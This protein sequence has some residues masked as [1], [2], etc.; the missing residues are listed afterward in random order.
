MKTLALALLVPAFALCSTIAPASAQTYQ[1]CEAKAVTK[2]T[3][4]AL[5]GVSKTSSINKCMRAP[6]EAQAAKAVDK[7]GKKLAGPTKNSF[8]A[9][10]L[11]GG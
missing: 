8:M 6:C 5:T 1:Q 7:N 2:T 3:G 9:K 10:C 4:K 11:K